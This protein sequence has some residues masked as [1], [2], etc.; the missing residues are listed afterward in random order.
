[1]FYHP[2]FSTPDYHLRS[3]YLLPGVRAGMCDMS[4]LAQCSSVP[5][6]SDV[7]LL[8][9][10][11]CG[12]QLHVYQW[13]DVRPGPHT[14]LGPHSISRRGAD[15]RHRDRNESRDQAEP[16]GRLASGSGPTPAWLVTRVLP[17]L[18]PGGA[19]YL[20]YNPSYCGVSIGRCQHPGPP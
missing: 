16:S 14:S 8:V 20:Q 7:S 12:V 17:T 1:M 15:T 10:A 11:P 3:G 13:L 9:L 2:T 18:G 5:T 19:G 6:L 4:C